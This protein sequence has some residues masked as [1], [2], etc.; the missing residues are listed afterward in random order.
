MGDKF[1]HKFL[2]HPGVLHEGERLLQTESCKNELLAGFYYT[3]VGATSFLSVGN[4]T[5]GLGLPTMSNYR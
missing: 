4:N 3:F 1:E 5:C 2:H